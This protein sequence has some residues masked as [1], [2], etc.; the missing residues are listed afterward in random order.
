[1]RKVLEDP[2]RA[3]KW[4]ERALAIFLISIPLILKFSDHFKDG[5]YRSSISNYVYMCN[6]Y[7]FGLLLGTAAMLFIFN[8]VIYFKKRQRYDPF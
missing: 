8:G 1:M 5:T 4:F 7:V 6:S 2:L 3:L